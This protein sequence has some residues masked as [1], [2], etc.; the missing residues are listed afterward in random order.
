MGYTKLFTFCETQSLKLLQ[1]SR[2]TFII[3]SPVFFLISWFSVHFFEKSA[4][5]SGIP[6]VLLALESEPLLIKRNLLRIRT[7]LFKVFGSCVALLG[8]ASIGREGPS[9]QIS[10]AIAYEVKKLFAKIDIKIENS[11]MII[12]GAAAGLAAAFNTPI[13]GIVFAIEE[14][15]REHIRSF[16]IGLLQGIMISG[17]VSQAL[18]GSY[19]Y[20]GLAPVTAFHLNSVGWIILVALITGVAGALFGDLLANAIVRVQRKPF[21][22]QVG[23]VVFSSVM[24]IILY[25]LCGSTVFYSGKTEINHWLF[26]SDF[27]SPLDCIA[28]FL[29]PFFSSLTGISGGIFAPSLSAG[30]SL[31]SLISSVFIPELKVNLALTGMIG[32]L[33]GVTRVPITSFILVLE[34]TDRHLAITTMMIATLV[35]HLASRLISSK[36][37]YEILLEEMKSRT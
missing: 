10:S 16:R 20:L 1:E 15:S 8:G 28:R 14:L 9:I 26:S 33:T 34:M 22:F 18:L 4:K 31:G 37:F 24:L 5:G 27:A 35:S 21:M 23:T 17:I 2:L 30:A 19:L 11:Y 7:I 3:L 32:F 13:G 29:G 12:T 6:Q 25:F 36:S